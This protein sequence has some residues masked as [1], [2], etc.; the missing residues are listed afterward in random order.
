MTNLKKTIEKI[1]CEYVFD[2]GMGRGISLLHDMDH[3]LHLISKTKNI[4][5][6][7]SFDARILISTENGK[8]KVCFT[9]RER[10]LGACYTLIVSMGFNV[11][12]CI[13]C[14]GDFFRKHSSDPKPRL[15]KMTCSEACSSSMKSKRAKIRKMLKG[16]RS[17]TESARMLMLSESVASAISG[18]RA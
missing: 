6:I 9:D 17:L 15:A 2:A 18:D 3:V 12:N 11:A 8:T 16:G 13:M 10:F 5:A 1:P 4:R 14:D 7:S